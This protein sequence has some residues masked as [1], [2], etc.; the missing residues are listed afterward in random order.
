MKKRSNIR[1]V[2]DRL[3]SMCAFG[4]SK[5]ADKRRNGGKPAKNKIYAR[6]TFEL[7]LAVCCRFAR[8]VKA[9]FDCTDMERARCYVA[10]YLRWRIALGR[11][12]WTVRAEASALAKLYQCSAADFGVALPV[13]RRQAVTQHRKAKWVGHFDP[14]AH[15]ELMAFCCS[16]GLRRHEILKIRP[17][18]VQE[19]AQNRATI[20]VLHG[21]GGKRRQ[22][23][24]LDSTPLK[25]AQRAAQQGEKYIF[26]QVP[27]YAPIHT[28]RRFYAQRLYESH[29][30]PLEQ[31]PRCE[32][33]VCRR[34]K[35]RT[36]YQKKAMAIVSANLGHSRIDV[37]TA[38]LD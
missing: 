11:S 18:D 5:H 21:K 26:P 29:T 17:E 25:L 24:S 38:Y 33:Y 36:V 14:A 7:Y 35:A 32:R 37:V 1:Q 34:D 10:D 31:V 19:V 3:R 4:E 13:R 22:V 23:T 15:R 2:Y 12:A 9:Q 16:T 8:W 20:H 6:K 27:K 30:V 28:W